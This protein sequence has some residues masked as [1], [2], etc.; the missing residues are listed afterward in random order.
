MEESEERYRV[1][2][3]STEDLVFLKD[4]QLRYVIVNK[5]NAE[6]FNKPEADIIG[7]TDFDLMPEG[8][9]RNC[10]S[11]DNLALSSEKV[12]IQREKVGDKDYECRKF[13][14]PLESGLYGVGGYIRDITQRNGCSNCPS[15][16]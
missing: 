11:T 14:V 2:I 7:K 9:A 3:N 6:F 1:F 8:V 15:E 4:E 13:K 16:K 10:Y 12:I 5:S